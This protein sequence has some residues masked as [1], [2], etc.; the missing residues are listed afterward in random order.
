MRVSAGHTMQKAITGK[1]PSKGANKSRSAQDRFLSQMLTEHLKVAVFLVNGIRLEGQIMSFD[2]H[3]ILLQGEVTD[4][5][6][7]HAVSTIQPITAA[8]ARTKRSVKAG[9]ARAAPSGAARAQPDNARAFSMGAEAA[10]PD[11]R[12]QPVVVIRAKR[13]SIKSV[14]DKS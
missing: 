11:T 5:V 13:R 10:V 6:Y 2:E 12:R 3:V 7:K 14:E 1:A 9:P 8:V 4:H